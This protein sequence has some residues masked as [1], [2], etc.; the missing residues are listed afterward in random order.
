MARR[1]RGPEQIVNKLRQAEV[2]WS[3]G[4]T[5]PEV[6]RKIAL[7]E[8]TCYRWRKQYRGPR[9]DQAKRFKELVT[10][11]RIGTPVVSVSFR[12]FPSRPRIRT[13][14]YLFSEASCPDQ[15]IRLLMTLP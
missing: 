1:R 5:V 7:T 12:R 3:K 6:C 14:P 8:Q 13:R 11:L 4:K 15:A 10:F 9:M 2:H